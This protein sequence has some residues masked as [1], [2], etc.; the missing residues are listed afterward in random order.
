MASNVEQSIKAAFR[1]LVFETPIEK[2][3]VSQICERAAIARKTFYVYFGTRRDA[4]CPDQPA[5]ATIF[6]R[7]KKQAG[8]HHGQD[9]IRCGQE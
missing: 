3:T 8:G 2:I 5:C 4:C 9:R 1:Q 6:N 7:E